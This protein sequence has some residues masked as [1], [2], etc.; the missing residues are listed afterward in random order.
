VDSGLAPAVRHLIHK[1][2]ID[3]S[4]RDW[5]VL[6]SQFSEAV[7]R[8]GLYF[9]PAESLSSELTSDRWVADLGGKC[10]SYADM[11]QLSM[12][13]FP[14]SPREMSIF[15]QYG[16]VGVDFSGR[17]AEVMKEGSCGLLPTFHRLLLHWNLIFRCAF[18]RGG[19]LS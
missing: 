18:H 13:A 1:K 16:S 4:P 12:L 5:V 9:R 14:P 8:H 17:R 7:E 15:S 2:R 3:P 11:D 6:R 19:C 10:S